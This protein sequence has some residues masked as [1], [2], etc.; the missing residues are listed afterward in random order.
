MRQ[1]SLLTAPIIGKGAVEILARDALDGLSDLYGKW[2]G[3]KTLA[4]EVDTS[5]GGPETST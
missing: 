3:V 2:L 5:I 1:I 4:E